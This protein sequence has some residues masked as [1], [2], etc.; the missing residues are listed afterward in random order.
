L[1]KFR[2]PE[3][4]R[5]KTSN[6]GQRQNPSIIEEKNA[7]IDRINQYHKHVEEKKKN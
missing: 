1:Y 5:P 3:T 4:D 6:G 2:N 7:H